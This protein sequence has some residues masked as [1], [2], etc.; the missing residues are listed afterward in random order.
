MMLTIPPVAG[1]KLG[2]ELDTSDGTEVLLGDLLGAF[3]LAFVGTELR[4]GA[5]L[6][7]ALGAAVSSPPPSLGTWLGSSDT[8]D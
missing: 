8:N 6:G 1:S 7:N 2:L 5:L 3:L 4:L